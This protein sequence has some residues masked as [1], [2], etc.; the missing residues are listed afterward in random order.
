MIKFNRFSKLDK[1]W[2]IDID[3]TIL[4]HN[5]HLKSGNKILENSKNFLLNIPKTDKIILLTGRPKKYK[6]ETIKYLRKH[7]IKF[8]NILFD[9]NIGERILINDKKP[10][11]LKTAYA[12]N[13]KRDKGIV[14]KNK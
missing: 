6:S 10:D 14:F 1:T 8:D 4:V 9:L 3:G 2:L 12:V 7:K 11:G 13:L 5:S